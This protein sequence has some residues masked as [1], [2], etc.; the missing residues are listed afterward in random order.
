M[1]HPAFPLFFVTLLLAV[2]CAPKEHILHIV[3]TG[4]VHG[5]WFDEPYVEGQ[6][7]KTS[8]MSVHAW[9]AIASSEARW[10]LNFGRF[11][12]FETTSSLKRLS[13]GHRAWESASVSM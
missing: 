10:W 6:S 4:D 7:N 13:S 8:L 11:R 12:W 2:S 9:V 1:K 5:N 3:T